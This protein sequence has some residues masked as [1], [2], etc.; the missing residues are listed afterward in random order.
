MSAFKR[1]K[2]AR[3]AHDRALE[4]VKKRRD[5]MTHLFAYVLVNLLLWGIWTVAALTGHTSFPWPIWVT[6]GWGIGIAFN[7]CGRLLPAADHRRRR[8]PRD[9]APRPASCGVSVN[10]ACW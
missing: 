7:A 3:D 9:G 8:A 1:H 2:R 6:F 4:R 5:F 10:P